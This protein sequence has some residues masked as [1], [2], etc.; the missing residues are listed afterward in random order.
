MITASISALI[1]LFLVDFSI[2][3]LNFKWIKFYNAFYHCF[4]IFQ[5]YFLNQQF[6]PDIEISNKFYYSI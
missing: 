6:K 2:W 4:L 3:N 5:E 1:N